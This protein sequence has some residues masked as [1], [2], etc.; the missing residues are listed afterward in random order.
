YPVQLDTGSS[1]L[2]IK[3]STSPL[4]NSTQSVRIYLCLYP[5]LYSIGWANGTVSYI[6]ANFANISIS[7]QAYLDVSSAQ[8]PALSYGADG[9]LGLGFTSLSQI[10]SVV[11]ATNSNAGR[12]FL[13]NLF[14]DNPS[15]PNFIAI[16]LQRS[17]DDENEVQGT[18]SIGEYDE[19]YTDV[20]NQD[21]ISTWPVDSPSRWNV[22][23]DA[24]LFGNG[25]AVLPTTTVPDVPSNRAVVLL[26]SGTSYTYAPTEI[27][28]AI[29]GDIDGASYDASLGQWIVPCDYE[30]DI[31]LQISD[32]IFPLH[33][34]D[35]SPTS[36]TDSSQCVGSFIPQSISVGEGQFDWLVGDN[37]LRAVYS[38]YDFG[39]FDSDGNM[40]Y[41]FVKLLSIVD[42]DDASKD[43]ASSRGS[44]AKTDIS[45]SLDQTVAAAA[46]TTSVTLSS[47]VA[48]TLDKIGKYFPAMLGVMALNALVILVLAGA[49][50][51]YLC[52]RRKRSKPIPRTAR[53][54]S[55][56]PFNAR[57]TYMSDMPSPASGASYHPV[58]TIMD[59]GLSIAGPPV[60][61]RSSYFAAG[62]PP[63]S[64]NPTFHPTTSGLSDDSMGPVVTNMRRTASSLQADDRP[65]STIVF[66]SHQAQSSL[67]ALGGPTDEP[68]TPPTPRFMSD[69]ARNRP[70]SMA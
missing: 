51:Y 60:G 55:T 33:P 64:P 14:K 68:F 42:P 39:D 57:Q 9:I 29:Y 23:L 26:D 13:Y 2:W 34:L 15:E 49:A 41:P 47:S 63:T 19:N 61:I 37:F 3:G 12:S 18:F 32:Q 43:F 28:K 8:N 11:N 58:S 48:E 65:H 45:Y 17:T 1:D 62:V 10:D 54:L 35:V 20:K 36:L 31:A 38:V 24:L 7:S 66:P 25:S 21:P 69:A 53:R 70:S 50:I 6:D 44:T 56:M 4:P 40:K 16:S 59:D 52:R 27:C 30:I 67:S 46:D 22:I 5:H